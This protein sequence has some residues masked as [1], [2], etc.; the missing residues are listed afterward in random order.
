MALV[1]WPSTTISGL[2]SYVSRSVNALLEMWQTTLGVTVQIENAESDKLNDLL[3]QGYHGQLFF[4][5]WC[6]D[7]PDPENFADTLFR[8]GASANLGKYSNPAL[9][10]LLDLA[11]I[12]PDV[13][14][15]IQL[16]QEAERIIINDAPA[17]FLNHNISF[18]LVSP[19]IHNYKVLMSSVPIVRFLSKG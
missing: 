18:V 3:H 1:K 11:R 2:G 13:R 10:R 15:R 4:Y 8:S 17:L 12:E 6:A 14:R 16:Y 7:Y 5:G 19:P 9:D